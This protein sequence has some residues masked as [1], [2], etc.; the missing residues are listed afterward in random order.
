[1]VEMGYMPDTKESLM[2]LMT[3]SALLMP[4]A[5]GVPTWQSEKPGEQLM[6]KMPG[7]F[8]GIFQ[9]G[10]ALNEEH[11]RRMAMWAKGV[12][13]SSA[14]RPLSERVAAFESA[15]KRQ[16]ALPEVEATWEKGAELRSQ[17]TALGMR[18]DGT[19]PRQ[20][21]DALQRLYTDLRRKCGA[22]E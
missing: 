9:P 12:P 21:L 1:M 14:E 2:F 20:R 7:Y 13:Q 11:G 18:D 22:K 4:R 6:I 5:K 3:A 19:E 16:K 17:L 8:N 10:E 15:L